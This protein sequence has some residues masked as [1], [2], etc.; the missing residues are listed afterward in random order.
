MSSEAGS[1]VLVGGSAGRTGTVPFRH[2]PLR[3]RLFD[4]LDGAAASLPQVF[5]RIVPLLMLLPAFILISFLVFGTIW[6]ADQSFREFSNITFTLG[7]EYTLINY[8]TIL[9][10][11]QY[12]SMIGRTVGSAILVSLLAVTFGLP[13]AYVMVR[14]QSP[15]LKK[16]LLVCVFLPFLL[17]AI[18]RGYA[19]LV[20]LGREG[21]VNKLLAVLG[22]EPAALMFNYTGV[23]IGLTQMYVP[24]AVMMLAPALTGIN[25][26][27][28]EAGQSLGAHWTRVFWTLVL[29]LARPGLI[30]AF[31]IILTLVFS[32]VAIPQI[33]GGGRADFITNVIMHTYIETGD[34]G[35]G[36]AL[37]LVVTVLTTGTVCLFYGIKAFTGRGG[38]AA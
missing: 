5:G 17:G 7:H 1:S 37:C 12:L 13:Y 31:V 11:S 8:Q 19:W 33:L 29:P 16:L 10:R 27:I 4:L 6:V 18:V 3:W 26:Q 23:L 9:E 24:M 25:E 21:L 32:D 38:S 15:A 36:A 28:E 2:Y 30:A 22:I 35:I 14:T 20:I 34:T